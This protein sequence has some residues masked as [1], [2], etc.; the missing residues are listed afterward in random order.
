MVFEIGYTGNHAVH[1]TIDQAL[2]YTPAQYLSTSPVR[3]QAV[4]DR[5]SPTVANPFAGLLPG[6]NLNGSTVGFTQLVQQYPA[7]HRRRPMSARTNACSSYFHALQMRLE[8]RFSQR[9]PVPGQLP[10]GPHHRQGQLPELVSARS[11][12]V[13]PISTVRTAS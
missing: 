3:D 2:N 9:L 4:I 12:S 7:V 6:T 11:K 5:N 13:P 1:L 10:V 8:K